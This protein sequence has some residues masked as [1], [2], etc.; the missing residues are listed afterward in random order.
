M[1]SVFLEAV[2]ASKAAKGSHISNM[3]LY[4]IEVTDYELESRLDLL[5]SE[6][7]RL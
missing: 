2:M 7:A 1:A 4:V 6:V 3:H 5:G